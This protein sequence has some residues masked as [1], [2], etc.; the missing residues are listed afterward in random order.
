MSG[1][2]SGPIALVGI[3]AL[4]DYVVRRI[5]THHERVGDEVTAELQDI[6]SLLHSTGHADAGTSRMSMFSAEA[7][8]TRSRNTPPVDMLD[9]NS[10][11]S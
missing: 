10:R 6:Q 5:K 7:S 1:L 8:S 9:P 11:P 2:I 3:V 4:H